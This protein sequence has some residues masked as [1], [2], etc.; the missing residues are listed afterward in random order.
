[1]F[2]YKITNKLNGMCYIGQ[3]TGPLHKRIRSH[4]KYAK[5]LNTSS[6]KIY[7]VIRG[8]RNHTKGLTFS[9]VENE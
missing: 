7:A 1:M 3:T 5:E 9:Y 8:K 4:F 2:I 6:G